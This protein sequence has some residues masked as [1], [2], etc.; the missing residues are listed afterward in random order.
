MEETTWNK[1][2]LQSPA[3]I[4][5]RGHILSAALQAAQLFGIVIVIINAI[6]INTPRSPFKNCF[7]K[8]N[9]KSRLLSAPTTQYIGADTA[10]TLS[11]CVSIKVK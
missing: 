7:N 1:L 10:M 2:H 3:N 11:R 8:S 5:G 6:A 9:R 4:W